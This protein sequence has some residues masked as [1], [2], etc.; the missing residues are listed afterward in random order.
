MEVQL[1]QVVPGLFAAHLR[2]E[3]FD[4]ELEPRW[5]RWRVSRNTLHGADDIA[6]VGKLEDAQ[7]AI[8]RWLSP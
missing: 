8:A 5:A 6:T 4:V 1:R 7:V 2:G 3:H